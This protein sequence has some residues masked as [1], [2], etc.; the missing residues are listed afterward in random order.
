MGLVW[1]QPGPTFPAQCSGRSP[2]QGPESHLSPRP[3]GARRQRP[4]STWVLRAHPPA[5]PAPALWPRIL[6][7]VPPIGGDRLFVV[8]PL[9]GR[10]VMSVDIACAQT[11]Q[12]S[13]P[14]WAAT[15]RGSWAC[16][17]PAVPALHRAATEPHRGRP[18]GAREGRGCVGCV[19]GA[20][21]PPRGCSLQGQGRE[22]HAEPSL[23]PSWH[24]DCVPVPGREG[25]RGGA[26][27][28]GMAGV[29]T[30]SPPRLPGA[31]E[32]REW[33]GSQEPW[34]WGFAP[35]RGLGVPRSSRSPS[36]S[37]EIPEPSPE[38]RPN[39]LSPPP[40]RVTRRVVHR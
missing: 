12:G 13:E 5:T 8:P 11:R 29:D 10:P 6:L 36:W 38:P 3:A 23:H 34:A 28:G 15:C 22:G 14:G 30:V 16:P 4:C 40:H 7:A 32:G 19:L 17:V 26:G 18:Q 33:R 2:P 21:G 25:I 39:P 20:R 37:W 1:G 35:P 31:T 9:A 27:R 24:Q